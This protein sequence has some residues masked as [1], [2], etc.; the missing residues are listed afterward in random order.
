MRLGILPV[1]FPGTTDFYANSIPYRLYYFQGTWAQLNGDVSKLKRFNETDA[2]MRIH[3]L[4]PTETYSDTGSSDNLDDASRLEVRMG[5]PGS[6]II[7][8]ALLNAA[9]EIIHYAALENWFEYT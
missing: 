6:Y 4:Y 7:V 3:Y 5:L 2:A 1:I 9:N 8:A